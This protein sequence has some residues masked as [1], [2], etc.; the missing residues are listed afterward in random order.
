MDTRQ[1]A[2]GIRQ[3]W[4]ALYMLALKRYLLKGYHSG[5]WITAASSA[6]SVLL[7]SGGSELPLVSTVGLR[8][9]DYY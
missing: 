6:L 1:R 4:R 2:A 8:E 5:H 9:L 3:P 7:S